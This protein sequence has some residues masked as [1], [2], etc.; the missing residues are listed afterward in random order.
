MQMARLGAMDLPTALASC[1]VLRSATPLGSPRSCSAQP[2]ARG[3]LLIIAAAF[4]PVG[5]VHAV[6]VWFGAW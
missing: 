2:M 5:I 4:F 6:G 1:C 3:P